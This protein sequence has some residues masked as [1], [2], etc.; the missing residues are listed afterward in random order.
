MSS[1]PAFTPL[2]TYSPHEGTSPKSQLD[3]A[4]DIKANLDKQGDQENER[5]D[6][7]LAEK[8]RHG[9]KMEE[10]NKRRRARGTHYPSGYLFHA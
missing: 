4:P 10:Q 2:P 3:F 1:D 9:D 8:Q 6:L 7:S 5:F